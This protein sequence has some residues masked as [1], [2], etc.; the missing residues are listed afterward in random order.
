MSETSKTVENGVID[1][2]TKF[3]NIKSI[4]DLDFSD[5]SQMGRGKTP[6]DIQEKCLN[7]CKD[8]L[9]GNW[10]QQTVQSIEVRRITGGLVNQIYFCGI[11]EPDSNANVPQEVALRFYGDFLIQF[12]DNTEGRLPD[13]IIS[14][15]Y[16]EKKLGPKL[17]GVF[18]GGQIQK[19]YKVQYL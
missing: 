3:K 13:I 1:I 12:L 8:Y 17:Y 4:D 5:L 16:S 10:C 6:D 7:L 14:L 15:I 11:R 18:E 9:C 19:F 2:E